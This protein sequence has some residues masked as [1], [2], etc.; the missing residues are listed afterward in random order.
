MARITKIY[1]QRLLDRNILPE[2]DSEKWIIGGRKRENHYYGLALRKFDNE[3]FEEAFEK[4]KSLQKGARRL[5]LSQEDIILITEALKDVAKRKLDY[6]KAHIH[7]YD[8]G[9]SAF[10]TKDANRY[11]KLQNDIDNGIKD[12]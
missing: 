8:G 9:L 4:W 12:V 1:Y 11:L 3:A 7:E 5:E 6:A 10:F 2:L